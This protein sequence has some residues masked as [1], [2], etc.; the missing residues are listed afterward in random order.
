[1]RTIPSLLS[2]LFLLAASPAQVVV[3]SPGAPPPA[4]AG[5][6]GKLDLP[7][8]KKKLADDRAWFGA[9]RE[10]ARRAI[11]DEEAV[12]DLIV[13]FCAETE[14]DPLVRDR[15]SVV[16]DEISRR[17]WM[18]ER[19][20]RLDEAVADLK[21]TLAKAKAAAGPSAETK[22]APV[23][24]E[25]ET[26]ARSLAQLEE[27]IAALDAEDPEFGEERTIEVDFGG[28]EE[29]EAAPPA[30]KPAEKKPAEKKGAAKEAQKQQ[31]AESTPRAARGDLRRVPWIRP[32]RDARAEAER[33]GR[34]ILCK[35]ILGGSNTPDPDGVPCGGKHDCE[36]S[37]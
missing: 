32:F 31:A 7:A 14:K 4:L 1:M 19:R 33:T 10:L 36:G 2:F 21:D 26:L 18:K 27:T 13:E 3:I 12:F 30:K 20:A 28:D 34:V 11:D 15:S 16:V 29:E 6:M 22:A 9:A 24:V 17:N 8:L 25:L 23:L 5:E 37:W 35:P